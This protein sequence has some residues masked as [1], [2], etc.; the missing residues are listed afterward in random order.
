MNK[1]LKAGL[2]K[3]EQTLVTTTKKKLLLHGHKWPE[4]LSLDVQAFVSFRLHTKQVI[5]TTVNIFFN[6]I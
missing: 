3:Y 5:S 4:P 1:H 2:R 6:R